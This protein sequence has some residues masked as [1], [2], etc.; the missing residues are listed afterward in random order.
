MHFNLY[1]PDVA[2]VCE[3]VT[4]LLMVIVR[5]TNGAGVKFMFGGWVLLI[6]GRWPLVARENEERRGG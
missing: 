5:E 4:E 3:G 2:R 6:K 1:T